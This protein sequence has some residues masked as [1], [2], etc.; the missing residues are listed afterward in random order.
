[1]KFSSLTLALSVV[2]AAGPL[3]T[4]TVTG[5]TPPLP[6]PPPL[7]SI[8]IVRENPTTSTTTTSSWIASAQPSSSSSSTLDKAALKLLEQ[9]TLRAEKEAAKDEKK[10]KIE[11]SRETFFEYEAKMAAEQEARI[12][13][14]EQ[15]ALAEVIKDNQEIERLKALEL[16]AEEQV[17]VAQ[18]P[19]EKAALLKEAK[20]LLNQEKQLERR[21]RKAERAEKVF[22][23]EEQQEQKILRQKVDAARAVSTIFMNQ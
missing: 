13:A 10:A 19:Q 14:A 6:P 12:E 15:K 23:A 11:K 4:T 20:K 16:K 3:V 22:L 7:A 8:S 18:T 9:E 5:F 21:E 1:M 17:V 2:T